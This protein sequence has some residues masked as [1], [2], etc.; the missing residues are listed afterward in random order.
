MGR[1]KMT[2]MKKLL[3]FAA[4]GLLAPAALEG[5]AVAE[6]GTAEV[7]MMLPSPTN[8]RAPVSGTPARLR[9]TDEEQPGIEMPAAALFEGNKDGIYFVMAT[10]LPPT[11]VG[12]PVRAA[13]HR[14]QLAAVPFTLAQDPTSGK[15]A[16]TAD[17]A[18]SKFVTN[19]TGNE[20]RNANAPVAKPVLGG[21]LVLAK[22]NYQASWHQRHQGATSS[23]STSTGVA[24]LGQT[25]AIAKNNDDCSMHQDGSPWAEVPKSATS[26]RLVIYAGCNGDGRDDGWAFIADIN[27]NE[28][29]TQCT[30]N[31]VADISL[32]PARGAVA[33]SLLGRHGSRTRRSAPGPRATP[34]RSA[35]ARGW[36]PSTSARARTARG[37][38]PHPLEEADRRPH[39]TR[40]ACAPTRCARCTS[41]IQTVDATTGQLVN[42]DMYHLALR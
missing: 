14:M 28:A 10:E 13:R 32:C 31:R 16:V 19:N 7:T 1:I 35:T 8:D 42:T 40:T 37:A 22:Y 38:E 23:C 30:Y 18:N 12:G 6:V 4:S 15:V 11:T 5:T 17:V 2:S 39:A 24:V 27:C 21:K 41:R 3:M 9:R 26:S 36:P 29:L 25:Q 34:S 33:R 20:Y